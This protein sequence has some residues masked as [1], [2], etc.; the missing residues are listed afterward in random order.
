MNVWKEVRDQAL[1]FG[2]G[3]VIALMLTSIFHVLGAV[4][5]V[6]IGAWIREIFQRVKKGG[7][8]YQCHQGC[9]LDLLFWLVGAVVGSS[10]GYIV[11]F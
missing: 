1:H 11:W 8:W 4:V 3:L 10:I 5:V 6:M 9:M 2:I 7:K